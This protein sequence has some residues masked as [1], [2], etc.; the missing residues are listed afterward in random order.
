M[1]LNEAIQHLQASLTDPS[2]DWGCD[3][4]RAEHE[5]LLRWLEDYW[6][7]KET[8]TEMTSAMHTLER[9]YCDATALLEIAVHDIEHFA[10]SKSPLKCMDLVKLRSVTFM[11]ACM[12]LPNVWRY[13]DEANELI[14]Q[15]KIGENYNTC[16]LCGKKISA[17]KQICHEC[18]VKYKIGWGDSI[19]A[20]L[21]EYI[22][23]LEGGKSDGQN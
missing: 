5:Q 12:E 2:H 7:L 20:K 14:Y 15:G 3:E 4:C 8:H 9:K 23:K 10:N 1:E 21:Q 6:E 11:G 18:E 16:Q 13:A 17:Y 19:T 22:Q